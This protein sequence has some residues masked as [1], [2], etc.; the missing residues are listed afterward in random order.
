ME[1][2]IGTICVSAEGEQ[3][4]TGRPPPLPQE[5]TI[6]YNHLRGQ[7]EGGG[8][9]AAESAHTTIKYVKKSV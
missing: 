8:G 7:A 5:K 1:A 2:N 4:G 3:G 9:G 6:I